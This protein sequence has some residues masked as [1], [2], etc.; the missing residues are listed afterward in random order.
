[1][2]AVKRFTESSILDDKK[3]TSLLAGN[4]SYVPPSFESIA[5]VTGTGSAGNLVFTSIPGTLN[6]CRLDLFLKI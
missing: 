4:P 3:Y 1:M 6:L 2:M 5:T